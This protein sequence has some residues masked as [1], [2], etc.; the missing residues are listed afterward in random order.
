[1]YLRGLITKPLDLEDQEWDLGRFK[2]MFSVIPPADLLTK[3]AAG[4]GMGDALSVPASWNSIC[5]C[6]DRIL[7]VSLSFNFL[8]KQLYIGEQRL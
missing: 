4:E 7:L 2:Q 3:P 1:M 8:R 6:F 5:G